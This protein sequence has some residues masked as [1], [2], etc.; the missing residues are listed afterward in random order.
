MEPIKTR[1]KAF[2]VTDKTF[3]SEMRKSTHQDEIMKME[4]ANLTSNK[5][6][7]NQYLVERRIERGEKEKDQEVQKR[8]S[9]YQSKLKDLGISSKLEDRIDDEGLP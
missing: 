7:F 1:M 5:D 2:S 8:W 6:K 9:L 3:V 4:Y